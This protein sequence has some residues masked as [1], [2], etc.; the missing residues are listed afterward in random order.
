MV[1]HAVPPVYQPER[2]ARRPLPQLQS[3]THNWTQVT[4][5]AKHVTW[6]ELKLLFRPDAAP[7][8]FQV[9]LF[10]VCQ[11]SRVSELLP[12]RQTH[13]QTQTSAPSAGVVHT[14]EST[15]TF[16]SASKPGGDEQTRFWTSVRGPEPGLL[17]PPSEV[18]NLQRASVRNSGPRPRPEVSCGRGLSWTGRLLRV[19]AA[20]FSPPGESPCWRWCAALTA[21]RGRTRL[22]GRRGERSMLVPPVITA[23]VPAFRAPHTPPPPP[24]L[25]HTETSS[26]THRFP[27]N[28][29]RQ[30]TRRTSRYDFLCCVSACVTVETTCW[31]WYR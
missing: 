27:P 29:C 4:L 25:P 7:S 3:H 15:R 13:Q 21:G 22:T 1:T 8:G 12:D 10:E 6:M 17:R 19:C 2:Q 23:S 24:P 11:R 5:A 30:R 16:R 18:L 31:M 14:G 9:P 26:N 28:V 20:C